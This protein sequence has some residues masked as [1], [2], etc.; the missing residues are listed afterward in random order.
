MRIKV[1]KA[2]DDNPKFISLN[3]SY[4]VENG[5]EFEV[6]DLFEDHGYIVKAPITEQAIIILRTEAVEV[7]SDEPQYDSPYMTEWIVAVDVGGMVSVLKAPNLHPSF[8]ENGKT[9]LDY[10]LPEDVENTPPGMY[11]WICSFHE[12]KDWESGLVDDWHFEVES[13]F[14]IMPA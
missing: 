1:T 3:K 12:E 4:G 13:S 14:L 8:T 6:I 11:R 10:G 5:D 2:Y 7:G 9:A